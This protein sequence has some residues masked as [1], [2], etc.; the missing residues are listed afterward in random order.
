MKILV[1]A[2]QLEIGGTQVNAIDLAAALR[3]VH[4]HEVVLFATPG[5]MVEAVRDRRLSFIPAPDPRFHPSPARMR[6]LREAVHSERPDL[7][8]VWDWWQ[9]LDAYYAVHVTMRLPMVVTDMMMSLTRLLPKQVPT[10]FGTPELVD[11]ARAAGRRRVELILPPVDVRLNAPDAVDPSPFRRACG[12][13]PGDITL[14]TISRLAESMKSESLLRTIDA[15]RILGRELPLRFVIVGEG[16]ARSTLEGR[17]AAANRTV[18]RRAVV[19]A[20]AAL[21][22]RPA[23][24]AADVVLG[25]GG[26]ALRAMAFGKPVVVLGEHGFAAPLT[27]AT[28]ASFYY[29]GIYGRGNGDAGNEGL[30]AIIRQLAQRADE[31]AALGAFA[32]RFVVQHYSLD[33][34]SARLAQFCEHAA[35]EIPPLH[36]S[37]ADGVRTAAVYARERRFFT[38]STLARRLRRWRARAFSSV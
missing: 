18:G 38:T 14:V 3:D 21:D 11:R 12:I 8:H 34:V 23:Y 28:A 15:V 9:C 1:F 33:T 10:T 35:A 27:P 16:D 22:S 29:G 17:A 6:A 20:G 31:R 4:G 7:L 32:R 37:V 36:V 13:E 2:H 25:M 19:L 5:P 24:A 30:V 26:S